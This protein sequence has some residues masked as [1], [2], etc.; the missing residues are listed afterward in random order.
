MLI[1]TLEHRNE[2]LNHTNNQSIFYSGEPVPDWE[3]NGVEVSAIYNFDL[4]RPIYY[5][6]FAHLQNTG[7]LN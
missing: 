6:I 1:I 5:I 7:A 3:T 2:P 4:G